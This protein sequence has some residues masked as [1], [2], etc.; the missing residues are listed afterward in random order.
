[1]SIKQQST[2]DSTD[3][4]NMPRSIP[5]WRNRDYLL[6][7]SGQ[8]VSTVGSQVSLVAF[9][10]LILALTNSPAEAGLMTALRALPYAFLC[11]PAGALVDR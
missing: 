8:A 6:L 7:L 4:R 9:P 1:M 3:E 5:L 10:L 11:L 2:P